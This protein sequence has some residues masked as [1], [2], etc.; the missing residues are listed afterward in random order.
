M[1]KA[2]SMDLRRRV[3]DA[4]E[5][6][7]LSCNRAAARYSASYFP[8]CAPTSAPTTSKRPDMLEPRVIPL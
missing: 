4:V 8:L 7:G 6:E 1:A 5:R 3:V 2:Y